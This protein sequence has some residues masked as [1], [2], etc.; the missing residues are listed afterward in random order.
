MSKDKLT[1]VEKNKAELLKNIKIEEVKNQVGFSNTIA[2]LFAVSDT[3]LKT[4]TNRI[5]YHLSDVEEIQGILSNIED[6]MIVDY[7]KDTKD[8][9]G[10]LVQTVKTVICLEDNKLIEYK[11]KTQYKFGGASEYYISDSKELL[12]TAKEPKIY[13]LSADEIIDKYDLNYHIPTALTPSLIAVRLE[14]FNGSDS[15]PISVIQYGI[16]KEDN[17]PTKREF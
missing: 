11:F 1:T 6:N 8:D 4:L 9:L 10:N 16:I 7:Y 12:N 3:E 5:N 2:E 13:G 14:S 15:T 17:I